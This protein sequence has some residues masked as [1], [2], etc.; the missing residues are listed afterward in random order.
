M[1]TSDKIRKP[2]EQGFILNKILS[3]AMLLMKRSHA[4]LL[5][6]METSQILSADALSVFVVGFA[7][8][9]MR[10]AA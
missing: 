5:S 8:D 6:M 10:A 9:I 2:L 7:D 1:V 3:Q 4:F